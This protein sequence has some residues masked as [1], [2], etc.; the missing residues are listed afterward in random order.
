MITLA[1]ATIEV[2]P[3]WA[4]GA[5]AHED[6]VI[7]RDVLLDASG[8]PWIPGSALAGSLRAHLAAA[9][10]PAGVKLM[11]A[12]HATRPRRHSLRRRLYGSSAPYSS[13]PRR[14]G[15]HPGTPAWKQPARPPSTAGGAPRG[16]GRCA[17][18][19]LL[20]AAGN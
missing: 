14:T 3:G 20:P 2:E 5:V 15:R 9:D 13:P 12:R 7:D 10:P 17:L 1:I 16:L 4:V 18:A 6:S 11:G 8:Q 19:A